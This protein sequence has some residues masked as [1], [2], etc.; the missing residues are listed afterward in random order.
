M[1]RRKRK[2]QKVILETFIHLLTKKKIEEITVKEICE[3]ADINRGTFYLNFIDKF[4]LLNEAIER[5]LSN[6]E[7]YCVLSFKENVEETKNALSQSID[8]LYA[9]KETIQLLYSADKEHYLKVK[10]KQQI[11]LTLKEVSPSLHK[12]DSEF[13]VSGITGVFENWFED[14]SISTVEM[15]ERLFLLISNFLLVNTAGD[16]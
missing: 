3:L 14:F 12:I 1:D 11:A 7:S 10:I 6:L 4:D 2:S 8:Y 16:L 9:H 13:L 15:K 5:E